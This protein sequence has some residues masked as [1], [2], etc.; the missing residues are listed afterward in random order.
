MEFC[1]EVHWLTMFYNF[2]TDKLKFELYRVI[3]WESLN[4][5]NCEVG[6]PERTE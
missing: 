6:R 3:C 5:L 1:T 4:I 2:A